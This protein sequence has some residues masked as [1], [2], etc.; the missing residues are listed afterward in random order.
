MTETQKFSTFEALT[1]DG[2]RA[3]ALGDGS[4][5]IERVVGPDNTPVGRAGFISAAEARALAY[6]FEN[7]KDLD[8][9]RFRSNL[10]PNR[11]V[12]PEAGKRGEHW[13]TMV[14]ERTGESIFINRKAVMNDPID[15]DVRKAYFATIRERG[16]WEDAKHG[17]VWILQFSD[18][19]KSAFTMDRSEPKI[20][21][22]GVWR[23]L[24]T[25][26]SGN[27]V[28]IRHGKQIFTA[29]TN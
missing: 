21:P 23:N 18:S 5:K 27:A 10:A 20:H 2:Y 15:E 6:V 13:A 8:L 16:D 3:T 9:G 29:E 14:N 24:D 17:D 1:S 11:V 22:A 28:S 4:I 19:T 25:Y 12:Y 26:M 7:Q